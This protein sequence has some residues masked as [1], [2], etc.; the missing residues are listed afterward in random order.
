M[1]T[2]APHVRT[3]RGTVEVADRIQDLTRFAPLAAAAEHRNPEASFDW[4][5]C[6]QRTLYPAAS[7]ARFLGLSRGAEPIAL[8]AANVDPDVLTPLDGKVGAL[9]TF[10]TT[11]Y[12]LHTAESAT[13]E[14]L[15]VLVRALREQ[16]GT[17]PVLEF[18][19]MDPQRPGY[20]LLREALRRQHLHVFE[21]VAHGNWYLPVHQ[22]WEQYLASLD[23]KLRHTIKRSRSKL[24]EQGGHLEFISEVADV[25]RGVAA[26]TQVYDKSWKRPEPVADFILEAAR[27]YARRG[28]LRLGLAWLNDQPIAAQLW[29]T[30]PYK[31]CIYKL[32]YDEEH[33]ALSPGT[34]LGAAMFERAFTMDRVSEIDYLVGDD[35]YKS[36]WMSHRRERWRLCAYDPF[37][38][39]GSAGLVRRQLRGLR[40]RFEAR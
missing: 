18:G 10:Y 19:P 22:T 17:P 3:D 2:G 9:S 4:L 31:A 11:E 13:V 20:A 28:W 1:I 24:L 40:D 38:L 39:R 37:T 15:G 6:L 8:I 16:A 25:P 29:W 12:E 14:D 23:G 32:A 33:K 7:G 30:T 5:D 27:A 26:Y 35:A 36:K 21:E 34:L